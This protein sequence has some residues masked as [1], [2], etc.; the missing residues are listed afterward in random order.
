MTKNKQNPNNYILL[1]STNTPKDDKTRKIKENNFGWLYVHILPGARSSYY[2]SFLFGTN[3]T[4]FL[5]HIQVAQPKTG[6][7]D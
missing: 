3:I 4:N 2:F 7:G 6:W 5:P 1:L